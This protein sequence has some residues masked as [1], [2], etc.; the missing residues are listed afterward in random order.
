[1]SIKLSAKNDALM[2]EFFKKILAA[3][4]SGNMTEDSAAN[5]LAHL[6]SAALQDNEGEVVSWVS[7]P[8][9]FESLLKRD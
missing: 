3:Y 2:I 1:M 9:I 8:E 6:F 4:K 5:N 7:K